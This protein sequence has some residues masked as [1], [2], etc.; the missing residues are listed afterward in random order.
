M[1]AVVIAALI[2][3]N[4][5]SDHGA[6]QHD[7]VQ[8]LASHRAAGKS[9]PKQVT[10]P[11]YAQLAAVT[12]PRDAAPGSA[13]LNPVWTLL[14]TRHGSLDRDEDHRDAHGN[15]NDMSVDMME[16]GLD[17]NL[18]LRPKSLEKPLLLAQAQVGNATGT[19]DQIGQWSAVIN[20][21]VIPIFTALLPNGK[22]LMW[23]SVGDAPTKSFPV[24]DF[25]RAA[26]WDPI[27]NTSARI[28]VSG[29]NIFLPASL[30]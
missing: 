21:P 24:H 26:V 15:V 3:C 19:P 30:T 18:G 13:L 28:D 29:F 20:M 10:T 8:D 7:F 6:H 5:W 11:P 23:D 12:I 17:P 22:V 14:D 4:A 25:T 9:Q 16:L 27:A 2:S 1:A